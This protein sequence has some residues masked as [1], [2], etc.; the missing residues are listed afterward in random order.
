MIDTKIDLSDVVRVGQL[1]KHVRMLTE[2]E[3]DLLDFHDVKP[4]I[5][6]NV[7]LILQKYKG[8]CD[9]LHDEKIVYVV[10]SNLIERIS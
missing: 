1:W 2:I 9:V 4:H 3:Q 7:S 6:Y 10:Y 8:G 5:G